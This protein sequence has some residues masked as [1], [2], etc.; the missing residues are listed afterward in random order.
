MD[1]VQLFEHCTVRWVSHARTPGQR[2]GLTRNAVVAAAHEV[3]TEHGLDALSMRAVARRLDVAPNALYSYVSSKQALVDLLLD[4][5]L[6]GVLAGVDPNAETGEPLTAL[7]ALLTATYDVLLQH[8]DL[9]P[10]YLVRQGARGPNA[11][12]LGDMVHAQLQAAGVR[13]GRVDQA[14]H[15]LIIHTIGFAAFAGHPNIDSDG[16]PG[17]SATAMRHDFTTG[18]TWLLDGLLADRPAGD[19]LVP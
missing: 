12:Q 9:L 19:T 18:L 13:G 8:A 11:H 17:R 3:L 7:H 15:V 4:S 10:T 16:R 5:V 1:D 2:A 14:R 6:A